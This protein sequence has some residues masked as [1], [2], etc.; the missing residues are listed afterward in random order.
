[1]LES[2]LDTFNEYKSFDDNINF[3]TPVAARATSLS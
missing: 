3:E 2:V 1:M